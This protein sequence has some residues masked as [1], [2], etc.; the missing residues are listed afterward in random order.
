M[1]M[2]GADVEQLRALARSF[3]SAATRLDQNRMTVGNAIRIQAW[4][5]PVA[6]RFRAEWDSAH[7]VKVAQAAAGL[8]DAASA[9][10]RNADDQDH[11]SRSDAG[12][13]QTVPA[14]IG[15]VPSLG[16]LL[17]EFVGGTTGMLKGIVGAIELPESIVE[18]G[19]TAAH[20]LM[21]GKGADAWTTFGAAAEATKLGRV[22]GAAGTTLGVISAG[23][24][25]YETVTKALEGDTQG[26]IYSGVK[27]LIGAA[28]V[29]PS[30]IQPFAAAVSIGIGVGELLSQNP[31]ISNAVTNVVAGAGDAIAR[32][33]SDVANAVGKVADGVG[34]AAGSFLDGVGKAAKKLWPW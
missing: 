13:V 8:R 30:P 27:T 20:V 17:M 19:H 21:S 10:R 23:F 2:Y 6:V 18:M 33:T 29:I 12:S 26:A 32:G 22:L 34:K 4:V 11:T 15:R 3:D 31:A 5:G 9:L 1:G 25:A 7:S 24:G 28:A 14:P 16:S